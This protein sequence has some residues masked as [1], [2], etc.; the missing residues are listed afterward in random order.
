V[1]HTLFH[2]TMMIALSVPILYYSTRDSFTDPSGGKKQVE[3]H[4]T[5]TQIQT[6]VIFRSLLSLDVP[7]TSILISESAR[8]FSGIRNLQTKTAQRIK[9]TSTKNLR[10]FS[11]RQEVEGGPLEDRE[12]ISLISY[13]FPRTTYIS[14]INIKFLTMKVALFLSLAVSAAAFSQVRVLL[15]S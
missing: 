6:R 13:V 9:R 3:S 10:Q 12:M 5:S 2:R 11:T 7:V 1:H 14:S 15:C 4:K 8:S